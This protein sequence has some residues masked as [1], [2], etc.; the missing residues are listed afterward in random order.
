VDARSV[1]TI[2]GYVR[3]RR[4]YVVPIEATWAAELDELDEVV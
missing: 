2:L 1:E 4:G 3:S